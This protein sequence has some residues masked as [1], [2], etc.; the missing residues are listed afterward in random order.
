MRTSLGFANFVQR[1]KR[2]YLF[3]N[4]M[5]GD[6]IRGVSRAVKKLSHAHAEAMERMQKSL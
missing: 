2:G 3:L 5:P 4:A 1:S 6:D